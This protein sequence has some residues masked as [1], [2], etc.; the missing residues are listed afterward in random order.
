MLLVCIKLANTLIS[1][2][3][4]IG[5]PYRQE[6]IGIISKDNKCIVQIKSAHPLL[7][8]GYFWIAPFSKFVFDQ[9][10]FGAMPKENKQEVVRIGISQMKK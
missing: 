1:Y 2:T 4:C 6:C 9:Q 3:S 5:F 10:V 7:M 8:K